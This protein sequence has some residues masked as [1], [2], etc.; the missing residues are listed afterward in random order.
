MDEKAFAPEMEAYLDHIIAQSPGRPVLQFNRVDFRLQ[1]LR[2]N[3]P[4]AQ[5]IHLYRNP[6]N[7]WMSMIQNDG[8]IPREYR[9]RRESLLPE[10]NAFYLWNWWRDLHFFMPF[11]KLSHLDHPYQIH[12]LLWRLS[13]MFGKEHANI[14]L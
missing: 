2:R 1:W 5:I 11:L 6:R 12:Y 7:Q 8:W 9:L 14:S 3:Y 13:Y 4:R 10:F